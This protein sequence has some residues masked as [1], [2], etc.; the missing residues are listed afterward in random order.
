MTFDY[1]RDDI[2]SV[3]AIPSE[4][5]ASLDVKRGLRHS[6]G[7]GVLAGLS[8]VSSVIGS[9]MTNGVMEPIDGQLRYRGIKIEDLVESSD[10]NFRFEMVVFLLLIGRLPTNDEC[11]H[12]TDYLSGQRVLSKELIDHYIRAIPSKNMMNKCQTVVSGLYSFDS[13]PESLD[14]YENLLKSLTLIAKMPLIVAY[15]YLLAYETNPTLVVPEPGMSTAEAMLYCLRQGQR[16][17][18]LEVDVMD[19]CLMLHAEHGGGNNSAFT[20]Y[21]V[22]S[23]GS[24]IYGTITAAIG[25]LKGP[26]HGAANKMVMDMMA[27]IQSNVTNWASDAEV[28]DYLSKIIQKKAHNG[29]GKIYGLGHAVYTKSDPRALILKAHAKSL[30]QQINRIKEYALY[31]RIERLGPTVFLNLKG[32]DKAIAPNVDFY[33]GFVYDCLNIPEE[34][35]TAMFALARTVG[36]CAHRIE[37]IV[38]GKRVI[39][40][41]YKFVE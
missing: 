5:Y 32:S 28:S 2:A 21:V 14:P 10:K 36:W 12:V 25:S 34:I 9:T 22:T 39:R 33:S 31:E 16:P 3:Y 11:Q 4:W 20:T 37:E 24:D 27:N 6:D 38:S 8:R 17:S 40:P 26:L 35:Y 13:D 29:T 15:A 1:L 41:K 7:S 18:A 23:T 19:L 30:A